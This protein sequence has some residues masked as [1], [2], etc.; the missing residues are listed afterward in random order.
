[1]AAPDLIVSF[2]T[3][4]VQGAP[5]F[6]E[7]G[8]LVFNARGYQNQLLCYS[9]VARVPGKAPRKFFLDLPE[10]K[11]V[12][13][14]RKRLNLTGLLA[15]VIAH[16]RGLDDLEID[17]ECCAPKPGPRGGK[18]KKRPFN[19]MLAGH[20]TRADLPGFRD[21]ATLKTSN[22]CRGTY[23]TID[24]PLVRQ[25]RLN[26]RHTLRASITINDTMLLAPAGFQALARLGE[27][28]G[29][30][31]LDPGNVTNED[32][33][34]VP[35]IQ[36][37]DLLRV[38]DRP[39][40]EQ[41][42][43]RD[44]EVVDRY[45]QR[46]D[47]FLQNELNIAVAEVPTLSSIGP[48][49]LNTLRGAQAANLTGKVHGE[50]GW[51]YRPEYAAHNAFMAN[52][53]FGGW[54]SSFY[55][56]LTPRGRYYDIDLVGAYAT[57]MSCLQEIAWST[58]RIST[59]MPLAEVARLD[60]IALARVRF[61]FPA[62]VRFPNLQ[63]RAG[64]MGLVTPRRGETYATG[65]ELT[66]ARN[67]GA[68]IEVLEGLT[69]DFVPG[70]DRPVLEILHDLTTI[71][72]KYP[73]GTLEE[74][75]AKEIA[76]SFY[77]KF[78]Q[79]VAGDRDAH[80]SQ[81][82]EQVVF[83]PE[84]G[85]HEPLPPSS[86]TAS[87][88]AAMITGWCRAVLA[89][90]LNGLPEG[91]LV[92]SVT[93]DGFLSDVPISQ[94]DTSGP[95]TQAWQQLRDLTTAKPG[96]PIIEVK[97]DARRL[98]QIKTRGTLTVEADEA[99]TPAEPVI[100]AKAGAKTPVHLMPVKDTVEESR[101]WIDVYRERTATT[102]YIDLQMVDIASQWQ[103]GSD[104]SNRD[105]ERGLSWDPDFKNRPVNVSEREGLLCFRTAPWE[106]LEDFLRIRH[107]H[108]RFHKGQGRG[109]QDPR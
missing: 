83:N 44:A 89:E 66:V 91:A 49:L 72:A 103:A 2:D 37:M 102:K 40:F 94:V 14:R 43:V 3:E 95:V 88:L 18:R 96:S 78:A 39:R 23:A 69:I 100:L 80:G 92:L 109:T 55:C 101:Y 90:L 34:A 107:R 61:A 56:G 36:R 79:A 29:L 22:A 45:L 33:V 71:R 51:E 57:S 7:A 10:P 62:S 30:D 106:T 73:K 5:V 81:G 64:E 12:R 74:R 82:F 97:H 67:L 20:F 108:T 104:L 50:R 58:F 11:G 16:M 75:A 15:R 87:H 54:N 13:D 99:A 52:C 84:S 31:K 19:I 25:V 35:A 42:A 26:G 41:Y 98:L 47:D 105:I 93:T 68:E 9:I 65:P 21:W 85:M 4:Y 59:A 86:I 32:G 17:E 28:V 48:K 27:V 76:N 38:Q 8:R 24:K 63:V 53:Y 1:V 46:L 60:R 70:G 77:G 6:D